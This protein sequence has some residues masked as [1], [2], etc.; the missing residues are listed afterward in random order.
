VSAA[1]G[2]SSGFL[3]RFAPFEPIYGVF[4][5]GDAGAKVQFSFAHQPFAGSGPASHIKVAYTQT[6]FWALDQ[7]SGP[8]RATTYSPEAFIDV[9]LDPTTQLAIGY[10]HD[11]NGEGP[12]TSIDVNRLYL[13]ANE[14]FALGK[15]WQLD[16]TPQGWFYVGTQGVA[17]DIERFM[18]YGALGA[19]IEQKHGIKLALYARGN[20]RTRQ[21]SAE[22]FLSYPVKRFGLGDSGIY[23]FGQAFHGYGEALSDYNIVDSHAR[24]GIALTR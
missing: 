18:G 4:G 17:D 9:P 20:P 21:G 13:R 11:S 2:T 16:V 19:S 10:R 5:T 8:F 12:A 23:V 14:R 1:R 3:D 24:I 15:G 22:L 6:M 7:P